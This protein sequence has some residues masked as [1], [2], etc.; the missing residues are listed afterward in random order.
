MYAKTKTKTPWRRRHEC[1]TREHRTGA[2]S[3]RPNWGDKGDHVNGAEY[4]GHDPVWPR[5]DTRPDPVVKGIGP[6]A[7]FW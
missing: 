1:V 5:C 4:L 7:G 3:C 6:R 2:G